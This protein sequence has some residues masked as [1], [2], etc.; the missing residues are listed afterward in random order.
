MWDQI[1]G[2]VTA[3]PSVFGCRFC[4]LQEKI[5][6]KDL[7]YKN[8]VREKNVIIKGSRFVVSSRMPVMCPV[9]PKYSSMGGLECSVAH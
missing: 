4:A 1:R 2:V 5:R 8:K 6:S 9:I 7:K 3:V